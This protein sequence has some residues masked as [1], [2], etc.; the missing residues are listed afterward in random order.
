MVFV[1]SS[2]LF[3]GSPV[4][5]SSPHGRQRVP[6]SV[7]DAELAPVRCPSCEPPRSRSLDLRERATLIEIHKT[8]CLDQAAPREPFRRRKP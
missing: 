7:I 3:G 2:C 1:M 6:M 4:Y 8:T 5:G